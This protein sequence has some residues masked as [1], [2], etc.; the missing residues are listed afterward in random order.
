[1]P[2]GSRRP[3]TPPPAA[4]TLPRVAVVALLA[5]L[6][7]GCGGL[8]SRPEIHHYSLEVIAPAVPPAAAAPGPPTAVAPLPVGISAIV[9]PPGLDR[10]EVAVRRDDGRL[11]VRGTELWAAPLETLVLHTLAFDLAGRLP[12]G[13]VVLP[14]QTQPA[15][16]L[17]SL[18]VAFE[19]LA[20]G[21]E[22]T[23]VLDAR[24]TLRTPGAA[25]LARR[26]RIAAPL[27]S[28]DSAEIAAATSRALAELADRLAA[29]L[30]R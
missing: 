6:A 25:D 2:G 15:G 28:L 17:R 4:A 1:M 26:E 11:D 27:A 30:A 22:R 13:A 21:P 18:D 29:E 23:F 16:G 8:F 12:E 20:A 24:W 9:L 7:A 3:P 10:R 14:G 19:E 5:A